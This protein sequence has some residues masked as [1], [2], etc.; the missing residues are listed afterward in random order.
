ME[1]LHA[2]A[3]SRAF[4]GVPFAFVVALASFLFFILV[5]A[6]YFLPAGLLAANAWEPAVGNSADPIRALPG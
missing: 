6:V 2:A 4:T 1:D 5:G 3:M